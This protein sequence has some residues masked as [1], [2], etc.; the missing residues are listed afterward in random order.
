[1]VIAKSRVSMKNAVRVRW[2]S[3]LLI[4]ALTLGCIY[5][6][7]IPFALFIGIA[8]WLAAD[9]LLRLLS[10]N[11]P[12]MFTILTHLANLSIIGSA[13]AQGGVLSYHHSHVLPVNA[14]LTD[15]VTIV[16]IVILLLVPVLSGQF[17]NMPA[18]E[19]KAVLAVICSGWFLAHL[20]LLRNFPGGF[21][22]TMFLALGVVSND[23]MAYIIGSLVGRTKLSAL[24]SPKKTI[25]G[26]VGGTIGTF[27][28]SLCAPWLLSALPFA[29][30]MILS[31][32]IAV[33]APCGDLVV[34]AMK[35]DAGVKDSS[36]LIPGHGGILDRASS[37]LLIAP[38]YYYAFI[39][40]L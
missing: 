16:W 20:I 39:S 8:S 6:G 2:I 31:T 15:A 26:L 38:V 33:L 19:A 5:L 11:R 32:L 30:I 14:N 40:L 28:V 34:S 35:R 12:P 29:A 1:M 18:I 10:A 22:A 4:G 17:R 27:L 23:S 24:L 36:T 3:S 9:E 25:E 21:S 13:W 7:A 37:F